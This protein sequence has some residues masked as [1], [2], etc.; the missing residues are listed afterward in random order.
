[1]TVLVTGATG[2]IGRHLS[3]ALTARQTPVLAL[4]RRPGE[5]AALQQQVTRLG[6]HGHLIR[7]LS[8]DLSAPELGLQNPLP[9]L[10]GIVHLG[11]SFAWQL[12]WRRARATNVEGSI[13]VAELAA[14]H[15]CRLVFVSGFTLE[16]AALM[17]SFGVNID[18]PSLTHW[19]DVYR[20]AGG[21]EA[22]KLEAAFAVRALA[23]SKALELVEV[24]PAAVAGHSQTGAIDPAQPLYQLI[25]SVARGRLSMLPG[26]PDHWL[27]LVPVDRLAD[28]LA[29]AVVATAPPARLLALDG[30]TPAFAEMIS[31]IAQT[32]GRKAPRHHI[33]LGLLKILLMLP[34]LAKRMNTY[35]EALHFI[36]THRYDTRVSDDFLASRGLLHSDIGGVIEKTAQHYADVASCKV[37]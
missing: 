25:D 18:R 10:A 4:M 36:H 27:P 23:E 32:L 24:Q 31:R 29:E 9:E 2:F 30:E 34:G 35:P 8:G 6:G 26:T 22:S 33:S 5:L 11:A 21:Y 3:A 15:G 13:A 20:R 14:A 17:R 28:I 1:M 19:P 12:D 7:A 16:N 37:A